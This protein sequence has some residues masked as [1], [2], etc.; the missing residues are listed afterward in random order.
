VIYVSR[1]N[2]ANFRRNRLMRLGL[3]L[4]LGRFG[5]GG[6]EAIEVGGIVSVVFLDTADDALE[7]VV[8]LWDDAERIGVHGVFAEFGISLDSL[9]TADPGFGLGVHQTFETPADRP[10]GRRGTLSVRRRDGRRR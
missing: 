2:K 4:G 5:V 8:D 7:T 1:R 3:R 6:L 9:E 10:S